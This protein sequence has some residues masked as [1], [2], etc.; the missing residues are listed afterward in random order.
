MAKI[1]HLKVTCPQCG[2]YTS[3]Y[4]EEGGSSAKVKCEHC[5]RIFEFGAGMMYEPVA[6]VSSIPQWAVISTVEI[7][8]T[9]TAA[10][11][12][13]KCQKTYNIVDVEIQDAIGGKDYGLL[14]PS[15]PA[16]RKLLGMESL[17][18]CGSCGAIA[19]SDCALESDGI[20]KM[21][22][23]F[24]KT[25]Y[26]IYSFIKPTVENISDKPKMKKNFFNWCLKVLKRLR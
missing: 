8:N 21:R 18:K 3:I 10:I 4:V 22:C 5:K 23:P 15:N 7:K 9:H 20:I 24:C 25:N 16:V 12:C 26:T 11:Q 13:K 1:A 19:C 2:K 6:Y 14:D 17:L